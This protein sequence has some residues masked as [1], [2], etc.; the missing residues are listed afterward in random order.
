MRAHLV[1][2]TVVSALLAGT[3]IAA[4]QPKAP[5]AAID[6]PAQ[7]LGDALSQLAEQTN[8]Q[9]V[10]YS[11]IGK[12]LITDR[13]VG[14]FTA[15]SALARLL[16][17]T[18]LRYEYIDARTIAIQSGKAKSGG[19]PGGADLPRSG[20]T[21]AGIGGMKLAAAE[22][23]AGAGARPQTPEDKEAAAPAADQNKGIPEILVKGARTSNTDIRRT[24]DDVQPYVVFDADELGRSMAPDLET[25][26]RTRLPMNQSRAS[27]GQTVNSSKG[28]QSSIDLRG[29]GPDQTLIL[30]NGRRMPGVARGLT[31]DQPDINGIPLSA[32]ERIE[33][34]PSTAG[35]IYGGGATGGVV[36]IILKRDFSDLALTARYDGTFA[37]GGTQRRLDATAGFTAEGGRTSL[38]VTAS[39]RDGNPL[40]MGDRDF[41]VRARALQDRNYHAAFLTLMSPV[42]GYTTNIR[43]MNGNDLVLKEGMRSLNSTIAHVPV[44]Y[45]GPDSDDGAAFLGTADQYNLA[46]ANDLLGQHRS[47]LNAPSVRSLQMSARRTFTDRIEAFVDVARYDNRSVSAGSGSVSGLVNVTLQPG[48]N[49]PFTE[50]VELSVPLVGYDISRV[51]T[52]VGSLSEQLSG[53]VI[54]RLPLEWMVQGEYSLGRSKATQ[55]YPRD[56]FTMDGNAALTD[57]RLDPLRDVNV[58]PLD[59]SPFYTAGNGG[60]YSAEFPGERENA[61]LRVSGP[62]LQLQGGPLRLAA[63]LERREMFTGDQVGATYAAGEGTPTFTYYGEI[64]SST[65]SGYAELTAPLV[66]ASN[67]RPGVLGLDLLA[68]YRYD[69][70]STRAR[71]VG[72]T[73]VDVPSP[74]GPFP[75][76]PY[77]TNKVTG[78]QYTLGLRYSPVESVTL[79][80][81][82]GEGILPPVSTQLSELEFP[83]FILGRHL[84]PKRGG[85]PVN[86]TTIERHTLVGSLLLRPEHSVSWSGGLIFT[87]AVVPGFRLSVD[88]TRIEKSDEIGSLGA[89]VLLDLEDHFPGVIVRNEL[90]EADAAL[91]YTGGTIR[92]FNS[93]FVNIA[94]SLMK[95]FDIQADYRW[96]TRLGSF[97][98]NVMATVQP[99]LL[100]QA[101]PDSETL[102]LVGYS[103]GPVKWRAN[104]GLRFSRGAWDVGW[105]MQYYDAYRVYSSTNSA[106][107]RNLLALWQG[108]EWIP[109][110]TYQDVYG[111]YRFEPGTGFAGGV[112][113]NTEVQISVQNV[114]NTSPPILASASAHSVAGYATEG[115]P[116]LRRYSIAFTKRF[117]R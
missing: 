59:F 114:L 107:N 89:Q 44:G 26:L 54:V 47:L 1:I 115:D 84:D 63:A 43:S 16:L 48:P 92:I 67:A 62:L 103:N 22:G 14:T 74:E 79:R 61:A 20:H 106:I 31:V 94:R 75:D 45:A 78:N 3:A 49:N 58:Y 46:M 57:G 80:V 117:G 101:A 73:I 86:T 112:L 27:N 82:Y 36:N 17:N 56:L 8:L 93:G 15:D 24:E 72:D 71:S 12:G 33:I 50:A 76:L 110:Q 10:F 4:E 97:A 104:A 40:Y 87:P 38:M 18:G 99:R 70:T 41:A 34:L 21:R 52:S 39:L 66:S 83:A 68:S 28:N 35:G 30:V 6:I 42:H 81:S 13:L 69:A 64:G 19:E 98:A 32:V 11:E 51:R 108:S 109:T 116:R 91:G 65:D 29:L 25:F 77:Q 105:N 9:F 37:G 90:T 85:L 100:Q 113:E 102:N 55:Q 7:P 5:A 53:G 96:E 60:R 23:T 2:L 95:A 111:R 88:Y